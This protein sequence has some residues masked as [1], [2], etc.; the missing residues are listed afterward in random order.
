[1]PILRFFV[2]PIFQADMVV[3][4]RDAH[5]MAIVSDSGMTNGTEVRCHTNLDEPLR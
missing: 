2:F 3:Y 1:M 4:M 5:V